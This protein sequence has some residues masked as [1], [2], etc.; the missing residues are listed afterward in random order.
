MAANSPQPGSASRTGAGCA[1]AAFAW[2]NP[3]SARLRSANILFWRWW[4]KRGSN[5]SPKGESTMTTAVERH[6][7][8]LSATR[9][10]QRCAARRRRCR[11]RK[12]VTS[13]LVL[14]CCAPLARTCDLAETNP[15]KSS[16]EAC[17]AKKCCARERPAGS[18]KGRLLGRPA[19]AEMRRSPLSA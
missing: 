15:R 3:R 7:R 14:G 6:A 8:Y 11:M 18:V 19:T 12:L 5:E 9:L 1:P 4:D 13:R 16:P 2:A 17:R 10:D